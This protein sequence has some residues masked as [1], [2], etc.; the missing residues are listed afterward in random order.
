MFL[1]DCGDATKPLGG[2]GSSVKTC[3]SVG[4]KL[5]K[6]QEDS[7]LPLN[8]CMKGM[9]CSSGVI[10]TRVPT[11]HL[12]VQA[13]ARAQDCGDTVTDLQ[14]RCTLRKTRPHTSRSTEQMCSLTIHSPESGSLI[15]RGHMTRSAMYFLKG[16]RWTRERHKPNVHLD[17][18]GEGEEHRHEHV[19]A[20]PDEAEQRPRAFLFPTSRNHFSRS[21]G[22][23][24][25]PGRA[26]RDGAV[27]EAPFGLFL[28]EAR[29]DFFPEFE[30][31]N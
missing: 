8:N 27:S 16:M 29:M 12:R 30:S 5:G 25:P 3:E 6:W 31:G 2:A 28:Q 22:S 20:P 7:L 18:G 13:N 1:L 19:A 15:C 26:G 10:I 21:K 24:N 23:T 14:T 17:V 9:K 11:C 4:N